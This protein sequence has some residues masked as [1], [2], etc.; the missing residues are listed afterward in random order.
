[1]DFKTSVGVWTEF[2][3]ELSG[4]ING[5]VIYWLAERLLAC[6]EGP[7]SHVL[8]TGRSTASLISLLIISVEEACLKI[9]KQMRRDRKPNLSGCFYVKLVK[10]L[11][12]SQVV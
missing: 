11:A 3:F 12:S 7:C 9:G 8:V 6:Q 2:S 4:S 10:I 1:M 5:S